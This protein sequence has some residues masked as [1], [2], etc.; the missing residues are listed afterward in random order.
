V[1]TVAFLTEASEIPTVLMHQMVKV[2]DDNFDSGFRYENIIC[3]RDPSMID[4][5]SGRCELCENVKV[6][7]TERQIALAV[8]LEPVRE[9]KRVTSLKVKTNRVKNREGVEQDYPQWGLI[10]QASSNFFSYFANYSD[11][12]GDIREVAWEIQREGGS[13][14]TKYH[15][16]LV[17]NGSSAVP[18][19]DLSE[20]VENI[21]TLDDLLEKMASEEKYAEV[22]DLDPNSQPSWG[23]KKKVESGNVP[24]GDRATEFEKIKQETINAY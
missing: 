2:P 13:T 6:D 5:F 4:E 12:N 19:P 14:D 9:G 20:I 10:M 22:A 1:R 3:K 11:T 23:G 24:S 17:M 15:P 18:L 8:E 16:F 7:P 21:P